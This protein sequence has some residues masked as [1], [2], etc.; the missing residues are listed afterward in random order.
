VRDAFELGANIIAYATGLEPPKPR[1]TEVQ[2]FK[3][4]PREKKAPRGYL[5]VAQIKHEGK[6]R[7]APQAMPNLM[8]EMRKLGLDVA[9]Q[10][11]EVRPLDRDFV[12]FKFLYMHGRG[13][14]QFSDPGELKKFRFTL[15][16]GGLLLADACC[17]SK[18]F[19][20]SFRDL[21]KQLWP[22][23]SLEPIPLND[24]LYSAELNGTAITTVRCRREGPDG[25][26]AD[27]EL[28]TVPPQLEGIRSNG[29][30]VVIYSKYDIGC[31]LE[32]HQS[33]DCLGHDH[34]SAVTLG[35]AAVLYA[36][37]R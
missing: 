35:K 16:S 26:R 25:K 31:A 33:T 4:D 10:T 6:W 27:A 14:F 9:L 17:G 18:D 12:E 11:E 24:D 23:Q 13:E 37:R 8:L 15:E 21:M 3:A 34:D 29:R 19:D 36:L 20:R 32:Q 30:W 5:K 28:R 7:P 1:L 22:K 2:V